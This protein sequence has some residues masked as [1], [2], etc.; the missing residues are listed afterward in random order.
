[1][2]NTMDMTY[3]PWRQTLS[4][5]SRILTILISALALVMVGGSHRAF[6]TLLQA[7]TTGYA[8]DSVVIYYSRRRILPKEV[9]TFSVM[10]SGH[11][12]RI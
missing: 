2:Q 10:R 7:W 6:R 11:L 4:Q 9:R 12:C 3:G 1:M 5:L 8:W